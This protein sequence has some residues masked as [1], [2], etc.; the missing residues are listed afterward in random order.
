MDAGA[1]QKRRRK[2]ARTTVEDEATTASGTGRKTTCSLCD[3]KLLTFSSLSNS[4]FRKIQ[5]CGGVAG[6]G[7]ALRCSAC[8]S[9]LTT[10]RPTQTPAV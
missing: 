7:T 3:S 1:K 5:P 8:N 6:A 2:R 9:V 10:L 4:S